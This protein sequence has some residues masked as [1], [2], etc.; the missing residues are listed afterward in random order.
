MIQTKIFNQVLL[1]V[2]FIIVWYVKYVHTYLFGYNTV[3]NNATEVV[4]TLYYGR[5]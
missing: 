5:H 1:I 2:Y 4:P 3:N